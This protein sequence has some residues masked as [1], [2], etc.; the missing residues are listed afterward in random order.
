MEIEFDPE[1]NARNMELRGIALRDAAHFEWESALIIPD[2]RQDY[3]ERR[4]RAFGFIDNRLHALVFTP[5]EGAIRVIS[6]RKA[7]RRE[8]LRYEKET[9]P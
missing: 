1:K 9:R 4:Y 7:N 3:G 8:V 5:R 2:T 6:L